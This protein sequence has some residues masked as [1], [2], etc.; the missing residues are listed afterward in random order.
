M[1]IEKD[2]MGQME[3][4]ESALYGA[5][6][7]RAVLNF[8]ISGHAMPPVFVNALGL[9]KASCA[10]ANQ[11]LGRLSKAKADLIRQAADEVFSGKHQNHFP[12]KQKML[13]FDLCLIA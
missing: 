9:V 6:T 13:F 8:P 1:R 10:S 2:S 12:D 7:Q 3:V 5:S 4:P 11:E